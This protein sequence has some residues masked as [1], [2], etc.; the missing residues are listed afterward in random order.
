MKMRELAEILLVA[1]KSAKRID[2]TFKLHAERLQMP[3]ADIQRVMDTVRDIERYT[4][5]K[6]AAL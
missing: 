1:R 5:D 4:D 6:L 3:L 2:C